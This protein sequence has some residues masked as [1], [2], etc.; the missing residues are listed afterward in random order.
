[1]SR[2]HQASLQRSISR[3]AILVTKEV[4]AKA[5]EGERYSLRETEQQFQLALSGRG[6]AIPQWGE[7]SLRFDE[8]I[9]MAHSQ[10]DSTNEEPHVYIGKVWDSGQ[11]C[12]VEVH[13]TGWLTDMNGDFTGATVRVGAYDP[14]NSKVRFKAR[15][16]LTFQGMSAPVDADEPS[17]DAGGD[18]T[19]NTPIG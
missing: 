9:Y 1:M 15:V 4:S 6:T 11:P 10:R 18:G 8:T 19:N 16:H 2:L 5:R 3:M 14:S 7:I 12:F 17:G 13:V